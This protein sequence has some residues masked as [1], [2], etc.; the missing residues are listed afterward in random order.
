MRG[1]KLAPHGSWRSPITAGSIAEG[2]IRLEEIDWE[3][4]V[5]EALKIGG[6]SRVH[7]NLIQLAIYQR[8]GRIQSDLMHYQYELKQR[9]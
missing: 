2:S 4:E 1:P 9:G 6:V 8:L 5:K 3:H 7:P